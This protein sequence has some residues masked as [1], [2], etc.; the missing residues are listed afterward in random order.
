MEVDMGTP[1][2]PKVSTETLAYPTLKEAAKAAGL[3]RQTLVKHLSEIQHRKAGRRVIISK[4]ALQ[5]WLE[6]QDAKEAA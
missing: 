6:G 1:K 4:A 5:R 2:S 3:A